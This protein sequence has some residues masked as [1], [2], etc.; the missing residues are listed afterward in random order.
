MTIE[1]VRRSMIAGFDRWAPNEGATSAAVAGLTLH[2]HYAPT[3]PHAGVMDASL[4]LVVAGQKRVVLGDHTYDYGPTHFLLTSIDLPVT[5]HVTGATPAA[6]YLGILLSI[7]LALVRAVLADLDRELLDAPTPLGIASAAVTLDLLDAVHRLC[8]FQ[9]QPDDI[10][11]LSETTQREIVYR[12]IT[13]PIGSRL[14]ALAST[15]GTSAGVI[16]A[17]DWLRQNFRERQSTAA[18]A[19]MSGMGVSTLHRRFR[20]LTAMSP[21]QYRKQLQLNEARRLMIVA[22]LDAASAAYEV[23]Y[24]SPTQFSREYRRTFGQP[25]ITSVAKLRNPVAQSPAAAR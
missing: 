23:G 18:L 17:L 21:V 7:D 25:P 15:E 20:A 4:S 9:D 11:A 19:G 22:G 10:G 5:A 8:R 6:P 13:S 12:L 1:S 16:K 24:E 14:R 3:S 2:R